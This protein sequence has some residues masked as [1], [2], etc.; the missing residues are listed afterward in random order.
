M[1]VFHRP[2]EADEHILRLLALRRAH[3]T[4]DIGHAFGLKSVR[5][6]VITDRV[7]RDDSDEE[8]RD[9]RAEYRFLNSAPLPG[10]KYARR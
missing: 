8:G 4:T 1:A 2:R 6:R 3:N 7:V 10:V 5:V 9:T